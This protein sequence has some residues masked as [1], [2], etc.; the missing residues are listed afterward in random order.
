MKIRLRSG[1]EV[2]TSAIHPNTLSIGVSAM[3]VTYDLC[4]R[5]RMVK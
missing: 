4:N 2:A 5:G 3:F 1:N